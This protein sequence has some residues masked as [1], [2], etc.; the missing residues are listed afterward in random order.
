VLGWWITEAVP[1]PVTAVLGV[2]IQ[3]PLVL[4]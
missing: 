3:V 1:L 2:L 4:Q